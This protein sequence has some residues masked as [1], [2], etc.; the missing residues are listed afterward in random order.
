MI[1]ETRVKISFYRFKFDATFYTIN[2]ALYDTFENA[3]FSRFVMVPRPFNSVISAYHNNCRLKSTANPAI[4]LAELNLHTVSHILNQY[5][6]YPSG[7]GPLFVIAPA[8][9]NTS[10]GIG[11]GAGIGSARS[12][13]IQC[14]SK[15]GIGSEVESSTESES[16]GSEVSFSSDSASASFVPNQTRLELSS[17]SDSASTPL[18]WLPSLV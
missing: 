7:N 17:D 9:R 1:G 6:I 2:L 3:I 16:E 13:T 15:R 4:G 8:S 11:S 14:E 12:V 5:N 10:D 18:P